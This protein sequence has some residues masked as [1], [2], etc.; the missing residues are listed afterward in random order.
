MLPQSIAVASVFFQNRGLGSSEPVSAVLDCL[1]S[2]RDAEAA[3]GW[4]GLYHGCLPLRTLR[5]CASQEQAIGRQETS[6]QPRRRQ[7]QFGCGYSTLPTPRSPREVSK[8]LSRITPARVA[9]RQG[10]V[11]PLISA[12]AIFPQ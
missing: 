3:E 1:F 2:R 9:S 6:F 4:N 7:F 10:E 12:V 8:S 11:P 5:L